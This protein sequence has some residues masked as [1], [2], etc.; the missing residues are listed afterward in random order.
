P[1]CPQG[2]IVPAVVW[3][4]AQAQPDGSVLLR[5]DARI[6]LPDE[7]AA[8]VVAQALQGTRCSVDLVSNFKSLAWQKLLQN[9]A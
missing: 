6:S 1:L 4:P 5:S 3:F 9:A 7:A 8:L 2:R